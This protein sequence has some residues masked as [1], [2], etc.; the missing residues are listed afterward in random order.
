MI[1][2]GDDTNRYMAQVDVL[3]AQVEA[4]RGW[5]RERAEA[6]EEDMDR[7]LV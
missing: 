5:D 3:K 2:D 4:E 1:S 7:D 6:L